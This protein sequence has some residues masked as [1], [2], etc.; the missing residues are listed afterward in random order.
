MATIFGISGSLRHGSYNAALL[1]GGATPGRG[2][3]GLAQAAWLPVLRTLGAA[4]WSGPR[5]QVSNAAMAFDAS[6]RL[7][8]EAARAAV[9]RHLGGFSEFIVRVGRAQ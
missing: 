4:F 2:G 7:V 5:V 9:A 1:R 6:G 8:D 3:T